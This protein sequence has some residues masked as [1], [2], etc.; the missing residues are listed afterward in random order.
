MVEFID[1]YKVL[2]LDQSASEKEIKKAYRTA[3]KKNH[4]DSAFAKKGKKAKKTMH[5]IIKAYE[6]L[7]AYCNNYKYPLIPSENEDM[8]AEDW[9]MDRFGQDPLWGKK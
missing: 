2:E 5:E 9:W 4:P 1:Y 6:T 7:L 8:E 3:S